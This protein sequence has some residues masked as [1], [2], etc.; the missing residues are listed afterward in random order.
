MRGVALSG[1]WS[2]SKG[3]ACLVKH[4][5]NAVTFVEELMTILIMIII[6]MSKSMN[7]RFHPRCW[8]GGVKSKQA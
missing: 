5:G 2:V 4:A 7:N 1:S 6:V 8:G 3:A